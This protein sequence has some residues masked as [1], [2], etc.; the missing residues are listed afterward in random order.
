MELCQVLE[1]IADNLPSN[2]ENQVCLVTARTVL[3]LV[4]SAHEF[5]EARLFP[6]VS[7]IS[8]PRI[9]FNASLERLRFEHWEDEAYAEEIA[10]GLRGFVSSESEVCAE[11]LSYML[12]GFFEGLRRHIAFEAECLVPLI[13]NQG[14]E[15]QHFV[16]PEGS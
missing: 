6:L 1:G 14:S 2:L 3:P 11:A 16:A 8:D 5:E 7:E 9:D 4:R 10:E 13:V 12:R 15:Q